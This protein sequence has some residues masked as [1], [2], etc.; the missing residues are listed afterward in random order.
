MPGQP[1]Y[2]YDV[3]ISFAE[4]ERHWV[5]GCLLPALGLPEERVITSQETKHS[6]SFQL[7]AAVVNEFERAV[8]SSR[9]TRLVLAEPTSPTSGPPLGSSWPPMRLWLSSAT[10]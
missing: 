3:F 7:G 4:G 5:E 6:E 9:Y 1:H 10:A 8:T 2:R